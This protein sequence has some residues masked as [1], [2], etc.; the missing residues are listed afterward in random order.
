M[1]DDMFGSASAR[2]V[3]AL[4][5][6]ICITTSFISVAGPSDHRER[7]LAIPRATP[8]IYAKAIP[9]SHTTHVL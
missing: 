5:S 1:E 2:E 8:T 7:G 9:R 6:E 4:E 3:R